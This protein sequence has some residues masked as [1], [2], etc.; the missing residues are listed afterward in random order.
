MYKDLTRK[1][2]IDLVEKIKLGDGSEDEITE[3]LNILADNVPDPNVSDLIF[4]SDI[5]L[6]SEEVVDKALS[7]KPILL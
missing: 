4:F 5:E 7:Y 3:W 6:S 2:L 1:E